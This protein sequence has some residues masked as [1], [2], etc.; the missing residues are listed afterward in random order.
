MPAPLCCFINI[1]W[2]CWCCIIFGSR[3][4]N[5]FELWWWVIK[6]VGCSLVLATILATGLDLFCTNPLPSLGNV[7]PL[8]VKLLA[9]CWCIKIRSGFRWDRAMSTSSKL[10]GP[11]WWPWWLEPW[12]TPFPYPLLFQDGGWGYW[13]VGWYLWNDNG[14]IGAGI[15]GGTPPPPPPLLLTSAATN[16]VFGGGGGGGDG[17]QEGGLTMEETEGALSIRIT[18]GW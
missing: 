8:A 10:L 11:A 13:K 17:E 15:P 6:D 14:A 16:S 12:I 3:S 18:S 7:P 2:C 5:E 4:D 9:E 1:N